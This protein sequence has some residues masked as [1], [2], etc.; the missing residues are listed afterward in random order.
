MIE[1]VKGLQQLAF[2]LGLEE[3][4]T[5]NFSNI[6]IKSMILIF[7]ILTK[8]IYVVQM[9]KIFIFS[10]HEMVRGKFLSILSK[11]QKKI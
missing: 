8:V 1:K 5:H 7:I 4:S 3:G 9:N 6:P 11:P 2:Q 10:A